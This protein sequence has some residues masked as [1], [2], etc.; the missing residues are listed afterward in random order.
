MLFGL[1]QLSRR[2]S[3]I[4]LF[5][6]MFVFLFVVVCHMCD[7]DSTIASIGRITQN[8]VNEFNF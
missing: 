1:R 8:L 5:L 4:F 3:W 2:I 6:P 7:K